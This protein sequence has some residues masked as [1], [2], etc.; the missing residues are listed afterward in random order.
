MAWRPGP[1]SH[2]DAGQG[3]GLSSAVDLDSSADGTGTPLEAAP[4]RRQ[5][6]GRTLVRGLGQTLI[7]FGLVA[8]LFVV[9]QLFVTNLFTMQH[10]HHLAQQIEQQWQDHP[11]VTAPQS[12][13]TAGAAPAVPALK[14]S[15]GQ[16]FAKVHIPR[17][18]GDWVVVEGVSQKQLA[19]GPGHYIGT[20][21]PGEQGNFSVAGHAIRSVFL[22]LAQLRPGDPVVVETQDYWFVY[23]VLGDPAT[24]NFLTDPSGIPGQETVLPTGV[25]VISPTPDKAA[26]DAPTGA[27]L[28]LTT[29][30][31]ATTAT[32]RL[33]VHARLDGQPISK[34]ST[35]DGPAALDG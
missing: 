18:G 6:G 25:Q 16:P 7:T 14:V 12:G 28:T 29:C 4:R 31:P 34:A 1:G 27:Y 17:L 9:Y 2:P 10:Q 13:T 22:S 20:A 3:I 32:Y 33:I 8:L 11:T 23:R 19:Q 5:G 30:T 35:P 15:V 24:G 26:G 21:M